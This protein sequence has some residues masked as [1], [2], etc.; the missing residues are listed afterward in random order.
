MRLFTAGQE[1]R[2][3]ST[4]IWAETAVESKL[5]KSIFQPSTAILLNTP[6]LN[7]HFF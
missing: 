6:H 4:A 2:K 7:I 5:S 1:I 3:Y